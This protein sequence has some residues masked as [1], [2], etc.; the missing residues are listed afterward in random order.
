MIR[1]SSI[2]YHHV[3]AACSP[4]FI[5][6]VCVSMLQAGG[7]TYEA[8]LSEPAVAALCK[9][10]IT[11]QGAYML[12][13]VIAHSDY[14][15]ATLQKRQMQINL[16]AGSPNLLNSLR[17]KLSSVFGKEDVWKALFEVQSQ[18]TASRLSKLYFQH[19]Y[20]EQFNDDAVMLMLNQLGSS[21]AFASIALLDLF[22][23][24]RAF[25]K[26]I[27]GDVEGREPARDAANTFLE[28]IAKHFPSPVNLVFIAGYLWTIYDI[29]GFVLNQKTM[30]GKIHSMLIKMR[31]L[32]EVAEHCYKQLLPYKELEETEYMVFLGALFD[33]RAG[34]MSSSFR[35]FVPELKN[36]AF[37][38][39]ASTWTSMGQVLVTYK[40]LMKCDREMI[41]L[42]KA[43]GAIDFYTS[44]ATLLNDVE[45]PWSLVAMQEC[46]PN[47][48]MSCTM[49]KLRSLADA[50]QFVSCNLAL[51]PQPMSVGSVLGGRALPLLQT[52]Y[53][54]I[55]MAHTLGIVPAQAAQMSHYDRILFY[56]GQH[57]NESNEQKL[58]VTQA[59]HVDMLLA[60]LATDLKDKRVLVM[61]HEPFKGVGGG[62]AAQSTQGLF[63]RLTQCNN[64]I[65]IIS[66][67]NHSLVGD[68][69][70]VSRISEQEYVVS[71]NEQQKRSL[72][73][74]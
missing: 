59:Y 64:V 20:L 10:F 23:H 11:A 31:N 41:K 17:H 5:F 47:V 26:N 56:A 6:L 43:L 44:L 57:I 62:V 25:S 37:N 22:R 4:L 35:H 19:K 61:V 74:L 48:P 36:D 13:E 12:K 2:L 32:V 34:I 38:P 40:W 69:I 3:K 1:L 8:P 58:Y 24:A 54:G 18:L 53:D 72:F 49:S 68:S 46:L 21:A 15:L 71:F 50:T 28:P 73:T 65:S 14:D 67:P 55:I 45:S 29:S 52:F 66:S 39:D 51:Q 7:P 27:R 16:F 42:C 9:P 70:Q 60:H 63:D 33:A 30:L